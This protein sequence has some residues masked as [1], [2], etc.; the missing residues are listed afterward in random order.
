MARQAWS[1]LAKFIGFLLLCLFVPAGTLRYTRAW[2]YVLLFTVCVSAITWYLQQRDPELLR[3][4]LAA[5]P[6]AER[7]RSQRIIQSIGAVGFLALF[8]VAGLDRRYAWSELPPWLSAVGDVLLVAGL[9]V[10]WL[11]F[12]ENSYTA[13][14]VEVAAGQPVIDTGPY[15]RV[16]HPM[17]AGSLI[18]LAGTPLALGSWWAFTGFVLLAFTI[19]VR[20]RAEEAFLA[21]ALPGYADYLAR[22]RHRLVPGLW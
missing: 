14:T 7:E 20:L 10:V 2:V 22:V 15:A 6:A 5:G 19:V 13:G 12:R 11:T 17:Y 4:R 8:V 1:A 3:R 21:R 16:R 18:F 9:G